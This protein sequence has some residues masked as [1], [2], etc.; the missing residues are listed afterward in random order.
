M[1]FLK[2]IRK[3]KNRTAIVLNGRTTI[4]Y[5][6]LIKDSKN[7]VNKIKKRS[8]VLILAGN[9]YETISSYVGIINIKSAVLI[10]DK[11][12]PRE[13]FINIVKKYN[14][15]FIFLPKQ[16]EIPS[17]YSKLC[18]FKNYQII[19][20]NVINKVKLN[21]DLA[22]LL[23]TSGTT[24]S[25]KFVKQSYK[26]YEDNSQKIINS[27]QINKNSSV[28]TTLPFSYTFGLSIINTHL[29]CGS[30]IVLNE[31]SVLNS[32]F[33]K[34]YDKF[35]PKNFYGV[36]FIFEMIDRIDYRKLIKNNL[37]VIANA[38]GKLDKKLFIKL[39]K[40]SKN[41]KIKFYNMYG[42]TEATSRM[43]VL[44]YKDSLKR[45]LSIG[46]PLEGGK[47][48]LKSDYNRIIN[49]TNVSGNL[50]YK[51]KNVSL[52]YSNSFKDLYKK[53]INKNIINTGDVAKFDEKGFFYIVGRKKRFVKLFGNRISLDEIESLV[54]KMGFKIKC[55]N[56]DNKLI[57]K[58]MSYKIEENKIKKKLS[59]LL[60]INPKFIDFKH[61]KNFYNKEKSL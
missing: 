28:I 9:N 60:R 26:N 23:T 45:P 21:K 6:Q 55:E 33:W 14:P 49:K 17:R 50:F 19:K 56:I 10:V 44:N 12:I 3:F 53:D 32:T 1:S 4:S 30:K 43:S 35:K 16:K 25:K 40:L 22:V 38:G 39:A 46:K 11:E 15:N 42:Q 20:Q 48:Y 54:L 57:I 7:T 34:L 13:F 41:N 29:I 59:G 27:I 47:F 51:G 31:F 52:G 18:E 8:L 36:P 58:C 37:D 61:Q 5:S 24:G 2:K